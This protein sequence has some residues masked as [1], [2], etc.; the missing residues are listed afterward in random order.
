MSETD[1]LKDLHAS[2]SRTRMHCKTPL[3]N[4]LAFE[5]LLVSFLDLRCNNDPHFGSINPSLGPMKPVDLHHRQDKLERSAVW[6]TIANLMGVILGL[7]SLDR[8]LRSDQILVVR[9]L[10]FAL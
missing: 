6:P 5:E 8:F 3:A 1:N 10:V 9:Q 7:G 4:A 2:S